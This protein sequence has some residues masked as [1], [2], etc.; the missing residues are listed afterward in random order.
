M[1]IM[2]FRTV[3]SSDDRFS[4]AGLK[5]TTVKSHALSRRVDVSV[6]VPAGCQNLSSLPVI[7]LLHGV[8]GSHWSWALNAGAHVSLQHMI[9]KSE[10]E[11][12]VLV[13]P[14]D[15]LWGDGSAY[16]THADADYEKW[17]AEELPALIRSEEACVDENSNFFIGGLSMGGWGAM[18]LGIRNSHVFSAISAHSA[19]T[20]L[21]EMKLFV[22]E[23]WSGYIAKH[24]VHSIIGLLENRKNELPAL[25]FDCGTSDLLIEGNRKLDAYLQTQSLDYIYEEFEGGHEWPYW[26]EHVKRSY[27]FFNEQ[28]KVGSVVNE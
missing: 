11:P 1:N 8:Y 7:V 17:I 21:D 18:W 25:R 19:I 14:S 9:E 2:T 24:S 26:E 28:S 13:M 6:F 20:H 15:G 27:T 5:F 4:M 3:K 23:D 12:H 16:V 10:I 22:E